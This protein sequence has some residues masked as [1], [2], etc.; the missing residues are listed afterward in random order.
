[1][2]AKNTINLGKKAVKAAYGAAKIVGDIDLGKNAVKAA[3][4]AAKKV[5]Q[6]TPEK[7]ETDETP[8]ETINRV[9]PV[10]SYSDLYNAYADTMNTMNNAF[11]AQ[12]A[13]QADDAAR[14][15]QIVGNQGKNALY[16]TQGLNGQGV[17]ETSLLQNEMSTGGTQGSVRS[18]YDAATREVALANEQ[19]LVDAQKDMGNQQVNYENQLESLMTSAGNDAADF[20]RQKQFD[21]ELKDIEDK[22]NE[23]IYER[24]AFEDFGTDYT[25]I[26]AFNRAISKLKRDGDV[27]NDWKIEY[28]RTQRDK[29]QKEVDKQKL[30]DAKNNFSKSL[31]K[32]TSTAQID[33]AITKILS[34]GDTSNDWKLTYLNKYRTILNRKEVEARKAAKTSKTSSKSKSK[35]SG[36]SGNDNNNNNNNQK[37]SNKKKIDHSGVSLD[38]T[39]KFNINYW[40]AGINKD[41]INKLNK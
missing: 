17:S 2:S 8:Q 27:S 12:N 3:Y 26:K 22:A 38:S 4:S 18:A 20:E 40:T 35:S 31:S 16:G 33:K 21:K 6:K 7:T 1:M 5:Q 9:L 14:Q 28:L 32:Y 25:T 39:N 10:N 29:L 30:A 13:A 37:K 23:T 15:L 41:A 11:A 24:Q 36:K 19:N 34:D